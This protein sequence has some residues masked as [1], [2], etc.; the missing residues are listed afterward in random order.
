MASVRFGTRADGTKL[1]FL[2]DD[3]LIG[4]TV[5]NLKSIDNIAGQLVLMEAYDLTYG[6]YSEE[7]ARDPL[8][9]VAM[10]KHEDYVTDGAVITLARRVMASKLPATTHTPLVDL[11][12]Y[13][14]VIL[15]QLLEQA[16]RK[17]ELE[18]K[19]ADKLKVHLDNMQ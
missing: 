4:K 12:E 17:V 1:E 8:Q 2:D 5:L 3:N 11:M 6:L 19:E 15:E 7:E 18:N 16:E 9:V 13:P 10:H 14:K